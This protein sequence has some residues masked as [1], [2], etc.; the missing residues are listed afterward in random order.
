MLDSGGKR[1]T[2]AR[3]ALPG[4]EGG[5]RSS[6]G[7]GVGGTEAFAAEARDQT[8]AVGGAK[9]PLATLLLG[10][11]MDGRA[12]LVGMDV[13]RGTVLTVSA[14]PDRPVMWQLP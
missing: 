12:G 14:D 8:L 5:E 1:T 6:S 2:F 11:E 9:L 3:S 13:L 4:V 10:D 7:R